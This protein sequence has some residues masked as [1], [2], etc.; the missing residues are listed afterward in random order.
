MALH[1]LWSILPRSSGQTMAPPLRS[2]YIWNDEGLLLLLS[3]YGRPLET[4]IIKPSASQRSLL[5]EFH[6]SP[7][8]DLGNSYSLSL[9][10]R[11]TNTF[12]RCLAPKQTKTLPLGK[13]E[14][15]DR[16]RFAVFRLSNWNG[17]LLYSCWYSEK[18]VCDCQSSAIQTSFHQWK[19]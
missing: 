4:G 17:P 9:H 19:A 3:R 11:V 16:Q 6:Y 10:H 5:R 14:E 8:S 1:S 7:A 12:F 15:L 18:D 2:M 13:E